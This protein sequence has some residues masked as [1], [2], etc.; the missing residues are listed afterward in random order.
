MS[1]SA[2]PWTLLLAVG[3]IDADLG[4]SLSSRTDWRIL[5]V[6]G[7]ELVDRY[8]DIAPDAVV[9]DVETLR[10]SVAELFKIR[11]RPMIAV[12]PDS[13]PVAR[14]AMTIGATG[15]LTLP[16]TV[17]AIATQVEL[18][19]RAFQQ[20]EKLQNEK[21]LLS[22]TLETRKLVERAKAIFMRRMKLDEAAAHR[23]LQQESQNRRIGL[24]EL[25]KRIIESEEIMA[26]AEGVER[27]ADTP[28]V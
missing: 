21:Q 23:R 8:R 5:R 15:W 18:T 4:Q 22:Q 19:V 28:A 6:T 9:L 10:L 16:L 1:E 27:R 2:A 14:D 11:R 20:I 7:D 24:A 17:D 12:G 3:T 13:V 26:M 25:A